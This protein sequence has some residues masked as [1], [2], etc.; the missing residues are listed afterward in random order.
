MVDLPSDP[1][2]VSGWLKQ[3]D[4]LRVEDRPIEAIAVAQQAIRSVPSANR[5]E[6]L[7]AW[8]LALLADVP[9]SQATL[10]LTSWIEEDPNDLD[11]RV[12][13]LRRSLVS[14]ALPGDRPRVGR[15]LPGHPGALAE[16]QEIL[17]DHP[18]HLGAREAVIDARLDLGEVDTARTLLEAW[19][20]SGSEDPRRLRLLSRIDLDFDGKPDRAAD[21][22]ARLLAST[23]HDWHLRARRSRALAMGGEAESARREAR[24]VDQLRERLS[25][26]RLGPRLAGA[27][28][29]LDDPEALDDL[30]VL[31]D[32]VGLTDLA[33]SWRAESA[34]RATFLPGRAGIGESSGD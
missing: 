9:E 13:L 3:I 23:P 11:A 14:E 30:A 20:G 31:C 1:R 12:A 6:I 7:R 19:P 8:T 28:R 16:L 26:D 18:D 17:G 32:S 24:L 21:S 5:T 22:L 34:L 27:L 10:A 33:D 25:P 4:R 29:R 2:D 15:S